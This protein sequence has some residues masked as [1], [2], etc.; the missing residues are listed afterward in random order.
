V[1][2]GSDGGPKWEGLGFGLRP[3]IAILRLRKELNLFANLRPA[4]LFDP[5]IEASTLSIPT[6]ARNR[7]SPGWKRRYRPPRAHGDPPRAD[8]SISSNVGRRLPST[9]SMSTRGSKS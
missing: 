9:L 3:E 7:K 2:F 1:L 4:T 8:S 5:L 6:M